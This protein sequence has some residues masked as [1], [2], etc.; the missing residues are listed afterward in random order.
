MVVYPWN[1]SWEIVRK[2]HIRERGVADGPS[3]GGSFSTPEP[4]LAF[5]RVFDG[6]WSKKQ[7]RVLSL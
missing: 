1:S 2:V 4:T 6:K 3:T 7:P 5:L